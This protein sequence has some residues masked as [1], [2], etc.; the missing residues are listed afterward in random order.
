MRSTVSPPRSHAPR[1]VRGAHDAAAPVSVGRSVRRAVAGARGTDWSPADSLRYSPGGCQDPEPGDGRRARG[2][3]DA[4]VRPRLRVRPVDVA[5]VY[6]PVL[7]CPTRG[8]LSH[9]LWR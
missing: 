1:T 3:P 2:R 6:T 5:V 8:S 7:G 4:P 9:R